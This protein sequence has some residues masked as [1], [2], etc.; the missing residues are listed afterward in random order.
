MNGATAACSVGSQK[1]SKEFS[2][3]FLDLGARAEVH[4][5]LEKNR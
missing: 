2:S 4:L 1:H 3:I 5:S